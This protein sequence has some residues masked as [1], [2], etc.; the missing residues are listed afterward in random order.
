MKILKKHRNLLIGVSI[1]DGYI[2]KNGYIDIWHSPK[3]K[4]LV[5]YKYNLLKPFCKIKP[6]TIMRGGFPSYGFRTQSFPFI[7]LLRRILYKKQGKTLSRQIL[8]RLGVRE[9]AIWWMD[10]GSMSK[11]I[12]KNTGNLR[13]AVFTLCTCMSKSQNQIII[14]WFKEKY[15]IKFGQR[16]M[17]NSYALICG[18]KEGRKLSKLL[19]PYIISSMKYK[20]LIE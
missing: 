15:D 1:G 9:I 20:I 18:T 17:K 6:Y 19:N 3:Q 10:D 12:N 2:N 4:E 11:K 16:K 14:N 8:N 5:D 13:A 7:K